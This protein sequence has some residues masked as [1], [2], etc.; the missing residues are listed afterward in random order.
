MNFCII[1]Y[2]LLYIMTIYLVQSYMYFYIIFIIYIK[3][4][5]ICDA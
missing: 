5:K 1:Q 3:N 4:S 2:E